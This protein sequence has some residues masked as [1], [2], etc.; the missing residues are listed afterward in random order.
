MAIL[1]DESAGPP[2]C[3][4][5]RPQN[6]YPPYDIIIGFL[7]VAFVVHAVSVLIWVHKYERFCNHDYENKEYI[8]RSVLLDGTLQREAISV[9]ETGAWDVEY[10]TDRY[11]WFYAG[12]FDIRE[13][14][15]DLQAT[16]SEVAAE[17]PKPDEEPDARR[18]ET[19]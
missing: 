18:K 2:K 3:L 17:V 10:L 1:L 12:K 19:P 6:A 5:G 15:R 13:Y 11:C 14:L 7:L 8:I 16:A 9:M 4:P